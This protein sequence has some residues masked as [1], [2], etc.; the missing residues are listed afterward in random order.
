M[1]AHYHGQVWN[2]SEFARSFGVSDHTVRR[3][4]DL[5]SSTFALRMVQPWPENLRADAGLGFTSPTMTRS[6][7][8]A[9]RDLECAHRDAVHAGSETFPL[10]PRV[11]GLAARRLL[12]DLQPL[13]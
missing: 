13:R 9:L 10:A 11:R 1:L 8:S 3:N 6:V 12:E 4:L 7:R 2:G 5:L